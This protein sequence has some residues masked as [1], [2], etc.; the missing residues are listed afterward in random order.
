VSIKDLANEPLLIFSRALDPQ[1]YHQI[2]E[3]F[4]HRGAVMNVALELES[5]LSMLNFVAI[6]SGCALLP[7]YLRC[8]SREGIVYR[9]LRGPNLV[10]TMAIV[11]KKGVGG[12]AG[13]FYQFVVH[14]FA[15]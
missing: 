5:L 15:K 11:K 9:P 4:R 8:V 7:D 10:K 2:E 6:G 14:T 13:M 12:L 1:T 3:L